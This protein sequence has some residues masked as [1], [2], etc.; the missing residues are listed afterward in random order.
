MHIKLLFTK[1]S[2][3][4]CIVVIIQTQSLL[5]LIGVSLRKDYCVISG[6]SL[7]VEQYFS[8]VHAKKKSWQLSLVNCGV[9]WGMA[10]Q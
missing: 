8:L 1:T 9:W 3:R 6:P 7:R 4:A 5:K 10:G 2:V